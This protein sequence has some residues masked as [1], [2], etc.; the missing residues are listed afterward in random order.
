MSEGLATCKTCRYWDAASDRC[1]RNP[2]RAVVDT[3]P[4]GSSVSFW[5]TA[6]AHEWCGEWAARRPTRQDPFPSEVNMR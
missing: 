4:T 6:F 3:S 1:H 5:P 2:P